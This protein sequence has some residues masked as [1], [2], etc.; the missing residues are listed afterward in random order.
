MSDPTPSR[1]VL[2][3]Q[4]SRERLSVAKA[5]GPGLI[6]GASDDDPSGIA[7]YSQMGAQFG[8]GM[9]WTL[10]FSYPLMGAI[11]DISARIGRVTGR[12][13]AANMRGHY[14]HWLVYSVVG[15]MLVANVANL[16]ADIGAMGAAAI[17]MLPGSSVFY[18]ILLGVISM[19]LIV[20]VPYHKY[21]SYLKWLTLALLSYV[22][23]C[24]VVKID[25]SAALLATI[26]PHVEWNKDFIAGL[27]A[28]LGTT[29]SP[30]LFFWQAEQEVEDEKKD[31]L[32][33]PLKRA[34]EQ[35]AFQI[36]R[37]R[38]DTYIGMGYSQLVA[39]FVMLSVAAT[40]HARHITDIDSA[41]KAAAA[42]RPIGPMASL[43]FSL[44]IIG[45][46]LLAVP[47]LAGSAA[48]GV[49]E[50]LKW[51]VGLE[52]RP[53]QAKGFYSILSGALVVGIALN[54]L[55]VNMIKALIW[56]AMLN[57][58]C[59]GPIMVVMML[60]ARNRKVMGQFT[61]S[62]R[63]HVLGWVS[64]IVMLICLVALAWTSL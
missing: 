62:P 63:L 14:H 61:I 13:I 3:D 31:P 22:A 47:I 45:T 42:L 10:L 1:P 50:A 12:G 57:G 55:H 2:Q 48:Y 41:E 23:V 24:F 54:F 30:Y 58:I 27:V 6:T 11:Q 25:W 39:F 5:L 35:A 52:R 16:A 51:P 17:L 37:I 21:V 36:P 33:K 38:L 19:V 20:F 29:I 64:T 44:G 56:S 28:V 8:F 9:L 15:I 34:P 18:A 46:G 53:L 26:L 43:L 7:T 32:Q 40:L 49:G 4:P 60:M 59:A